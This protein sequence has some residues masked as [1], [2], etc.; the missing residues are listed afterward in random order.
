MM[1]T[2]MYYV[3]AVLMILTALLTFVQQAEYFTSKDTGRRN[4]L[5]KKINHNEVVSLLLLIVTL[6]LNR[7]A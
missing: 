4:F 7:G 2:I 6:L 3:F 1:A 5:R